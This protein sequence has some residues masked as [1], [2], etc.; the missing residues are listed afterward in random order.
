MMRQSGTMRAASRLLVSHPIVCLFAALAAVV[1]VGVLGPIKVVHAADVAV[2][3]ENFAKPPTGTTVVSDTLFSGGKALKFT[4]DGIASHTVTCST[5]CDVVLMARAG[6]SGGRPSFSVNNS[7]PQPI[8]TSNQVA[9]EPYRFM[10]LP[11]GSNEI[12]VTASGTG[13]GHNAFLDVAS[14]PADGGGGTPSQEAACAD[15]VDND[16]DLKTDFGGTNGDPGCLSATDNDET[17]P[18]GG[19]DPVFVGAGDIASCAST[20]DEATAKLLDDIVA[21]APSTTTVFTAGDDAYESGTATEFTNCYNPTWGRHQ[22]ITR[23]TVGNHEYYS[24]AN[25]SGYF[26]YF[27]SILSAAGDTG[28]GYYSYDLGSWHMIALNSNCSFVACAA[29]S[30]Q[31]QWLKADLAAHSNACTLAYWHHPR[32]SS[33]LSS[34]GNSSMKPFWD[35]LY[36]APNKAEV[37]LN[38][39]VHNYERFAP[40]TPSGVADPAQGIRE[41]VVGTGGKSLN[42]FTNKG[43]ANSQ[44]RYASAYGVLKLTLHPSSYDWQFVTAPGGTVADSGSGSCHS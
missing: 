17:D 24:T 28:Q 27:G 14:F 4:A 9:P 39:H 15:G 29:G 6:Q 21:K 20:G 38:G 3:G 36:A 23:P 40:Q 8:T 5:P 26:G 12:R 34:G 43:V 35:A 41:Y 37:V 1:V 13:T 10:N 19:T 11:A 42:T 2:E 22:A 44:V 25:A 16:G 31:E 32:F 33:K 30:A 7:T 18:A